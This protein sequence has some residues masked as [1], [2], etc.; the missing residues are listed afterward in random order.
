MGNIVDFLVDNMEATSEVKELQ[1]SE[2][3]KDFKF[4][5][6]PVN[7]KDFNKFKESCR[8]V[9]KKTVT[10]DDAKF[11]ELLILKSCVEPNFNDTQFIEKAGAKTPEELINKVLK[12]GEIQ[13]LTNAITE[14]SGFDQEGIDEASEEAKN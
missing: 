9:K 13:E 6:K 5:I 8:T 12:A 10:F 11:N 3:L 4:K 2:R 7:G 14:L 1:L